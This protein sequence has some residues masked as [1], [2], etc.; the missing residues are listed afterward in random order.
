LVLYKIQNVFLYLQTETQRE[1]TPVVMVEM[2]LAMQSH[3]LPKT[4]SKPLT[5][6]PCGVSLHCQI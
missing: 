4:S 5:V 6:A 1:E 3:L 2:A